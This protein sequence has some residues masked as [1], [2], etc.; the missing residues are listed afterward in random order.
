MKTPLYCSILAVILGSPLSGAAGPALI[1]G[2]EFAQAVGSAPD[3]ARWS[4]DLGAGGWGN[5]ELQTY[6]DTRENSF[7]TA[8][9]GALDGRAL[10]EVDPGRLM[11]MLCFPPWHSAAGGCALRFP[12]LRRERI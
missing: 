1:W 9:G 12:C 6:T 7:I 3:A 4:Y 10:A 8:D 5:N 2:D 11:G